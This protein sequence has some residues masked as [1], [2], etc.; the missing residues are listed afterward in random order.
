MLEK[1]FVSS[2][3]PSCD[4][5]FN[6]DGSPY[7]LRLGSTTVVDCAT[8]HTASQTTGCRSTVVAQLAGLT[9]LE[10]LVHSQLMPGRS[11]VAAGI[12]Q[13]HCNAGC[14]GPPTGERD[15]LAHVFLP[16]HVTHASPGNSCLTNSHCGFPV[17]VEGLEPGEE[18]ILSTATVYKRHGCRQAVLHKGEWRLTTAD[19]IPPEL[20]ACSLGAKFWSAPE[21]VEVA[22]V[23]LEFEV[24]HV[25]KDNTAV[26]LAVIQHDADGT[27]TGGQPAAASLISALSNR[28]C[29]DHTG[30]APHNLVCSTSSTALG[31]LQATWPSAAC[32]ATGCVQ[33]TCVDGLSVLMDG[34][35]PGEF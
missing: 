5:L 15:L 35:A 29:S 1:Q 20:M 12:V 26:A 21:T 8:A 23:R 24:C 32:A 6:L 16:L 10:T 27:L 28:T 13:V 17:H 3:G 18:Y 22:K 2:P 14:D 7:A 34:Y 19:N 4:G 25:S 33:H 30:A 9:C 11:V 31:N